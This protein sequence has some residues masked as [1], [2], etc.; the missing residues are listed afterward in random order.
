MTDP[1]I[2]A[3][4]AVSA[5]NEHWL[6][7]ALAA[8]LLSATFFWGMRFLL[9]FAVAFIPAA[10]LPLVRLGY[11]RGLGAVLA[12]GALGAALAGAFALLLRQS[13]AESAVVY[14]AAAAVCGVAG[15]FA[16][17]LQPSAVFLGLCLYGALGVAGFAFAGTPS[18]E[19]IGKE[20]DSYSKLWM[21]SSRQSGADPETLKS[22]QAALDSARTISVEHAPGLAAMLWVILAGVAFFLGLRLGRGGA[23][24]PDFSVFRLPPLLAALFVLSGAA[25][26]LGPGEGRRIALDV[27]GPLLVLYFLAGLSIIAFFA[28]R[29]LRTRFFRAALYVLAFCFPFSVATAGLGLF[30][31]YFDIRRR[32]EKRVNGSSE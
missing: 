30:D 13:P 14:L 11:R 4:P 23:P 2:E 21:D 12:A 20:F 32:A 19:E 5:Q 15:A 8:A 31:W 24:G 27:L 7:E 22:L 26:A 6:G 29:W 28:R 3:I 17:K 10:A 18:R 1:D 25:A 9:I 16:R